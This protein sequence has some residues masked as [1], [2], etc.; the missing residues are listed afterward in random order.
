MF[1]KTARFYDAIYSWKDY[2]R[3]T[4][5]LNTFIEKHKQSE[6]KTLL[7]VACGTGGHIPY[8][9]QHHYHAE[10]LDLDEALL[11][12]ARHRAPDVPFHHLDMQ[13]FNLGKQ[14]D[15]VTCLFSSIG[16]VRTVE[17]LDQTLRTFAHH[18]KPGGVVLVEP[19]FSF[20]D[21]DFTRTHATFVD[22]EDF[23]IA[24]MSSV[25]VEDHVSIF[26]FHYLIATPNHV[27]YL[28]E[29]HALGL[30]TP[31]EY[32]AAFQQAGLKVHYDPDGLMGRG[33]YIGVKSDRR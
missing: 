13:H 27:E 18:T 21:L 15:V 22:E 16:Y 32:R 19:W 24:R 10:G 28:T 6:G 30:F 3:E 25:K 31:E 9:R 7:D 11:K 2:E 29:T 17:A 1:T 23:K 33:L 4:L 14:F 12:I 20:E 5:T 26:T 8:L